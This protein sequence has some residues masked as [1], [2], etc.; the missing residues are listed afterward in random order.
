MRT[1]RGPG[2]QH[3]VGRAVLSSAK[4]FLVL[5]VAVQNYLGFDNYASCQKNDFGRE[6]S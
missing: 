5:T 1:D 6:K 3:G 4:T 2:K